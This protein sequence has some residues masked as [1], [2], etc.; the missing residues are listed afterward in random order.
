MKYSC[1]KCARALN[2]RNGIVLIGELGERKTVFV[3]DPEPGKYDIDIADDQAVE[4][5]TKWEFSCPLCNENLTTDF[6]SRLAQLQMTEG[7]EIRTVV[8][9]KVCNEHATF[10][11]G[12]EHMESLGDK[13][14]DYL[15]K[16]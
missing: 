3:F 12:G 2:M 1:P 5:G 10:V 15:D 8:F 9:S 7:D 14:G 16:K 4:P 11:L 13:A 6:N